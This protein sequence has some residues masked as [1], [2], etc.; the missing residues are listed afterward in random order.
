MIVKTVLSEKK[1]SEEDAVTDK[2]H[3]LSASSEEYKNFDRN[4][5]DMANLREAF[6]GGPAESLAN[7]E[8]S[9][10]KATNPENT[11][12]GTGRWTDEEHLRFEEALRLY[13]KDWNLI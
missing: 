13:G 6:I 3:A 8:N 7:N 12:Q 4:A 10:S 1:R 5:L 11:T 9:E 2:V